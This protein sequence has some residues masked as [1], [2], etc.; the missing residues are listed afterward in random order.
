MVSNEDKLVEFIRYE[1]P[2]GHPIMQ[3][4]Y[5]DNFW[6]CAPCKAFK[7]KKIH[8]VADAGHALGETHRREL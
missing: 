2:E 5:I 8:C 6:V 7:E 4:E 3:S 1:A